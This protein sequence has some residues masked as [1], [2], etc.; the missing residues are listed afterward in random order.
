MMKLIAGNIFLVGHTWQ[1][2]SVW[3]VDMLMHVLLK[4]N[5]I[6]Q[7]VIRYFQG[8]KVCSIGMPCLAAMA[9]CNVNSSIGM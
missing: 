5:C 7:S 6:N 9:L 1:V 4:S 2:F 3:Q 8:K